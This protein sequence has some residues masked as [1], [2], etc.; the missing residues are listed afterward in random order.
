MKKFFARLF[1]RWATEVFGPKCAY[2]HRR[3]GP[4]QD[5]THYP[6]YSGSIFHIDPCFHNHMAGE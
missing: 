3:I 1:D 6:A 4:N 2:C 5:R